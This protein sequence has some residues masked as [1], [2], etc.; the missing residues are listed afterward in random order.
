MKRAALVLRPAACQADFCR[1]ALSLSLLFRRQAGLTSGNACT[2]LLQ[3]MSSTGV[4]LV[5]VKKL[6]EKAR[7]SCYSKDRH[8]LP[9]PSSR[10]DGEEEGL[11][12]PLLSGSAGST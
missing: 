9:E 11:P 10:P 12:T 1:S 8:G 6:F 2:Q 7:D 5:V 4:T 3:E